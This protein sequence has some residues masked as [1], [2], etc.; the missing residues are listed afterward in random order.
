MR[1]WS[2]RCHQ[3]VA[4][5]ESQQ[6]KGGWIL[7]LSEI[8]CDDSPVSEIICGRFLSYEHT[9]GYFKEPTVCVTPE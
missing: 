7:L 5:T 1:S 2:S 8:D 6:L 3:G 4:G 9:S